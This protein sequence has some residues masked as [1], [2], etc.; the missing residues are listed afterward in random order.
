[1]MKHLLYIALAV[2]AAGCASAGTSTSGNSGNGGGSSASASGKALECGGASYY[3]DSLAGNSTAS[4]EPYAPGKLTAAH[5]TLDFGTVVRVE[6]KDGGGS[7]TVRVNDRGPFTPGRV[8]D[9]SRTAAERIDLITD[10]VTDVCIY[11]Q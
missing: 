9:L 6:R 1:M 3:A 5:K 7:V 11:V 8:I 2:G 10:G 4:G